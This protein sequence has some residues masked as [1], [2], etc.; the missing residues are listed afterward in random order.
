M[1][2]TITLDFIFKIKT[3]SREVSIVSFSKI[4]SKKKKMIVTKTMNLYASWK[5]LL[6]VKWI[7]IM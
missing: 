3:Y 7:V 6:V 2:T 1:I 4:E 5:N